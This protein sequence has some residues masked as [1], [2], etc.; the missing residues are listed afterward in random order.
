MYV[1]IKS[2]PG[3]WTVGFYKPDGKFEPASDHTVEDEAA[4]RVIELNGGGVHPE[5]IGDRVHRDM[6]RGADR[7]RFAM[8]ALT[9]ML[10]KCDGIDARNGVRD[11]AANYAEVAY[12]LADEMLAERGRP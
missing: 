2:E 4:D 11:Y 8:A 3:L 9:G 1:Y 7:D 10:P 5:I 6:L 12:R